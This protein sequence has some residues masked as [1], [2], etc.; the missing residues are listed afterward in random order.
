MTVIDVTDGTVIVVTIA[1][2]VV[3]DTTDVTADPAAEAPM[4]ADGTMIADVM[5][6]ATT[7][8]VTM[9]VEEVEAEVMIAAVAATTEVLVNFWHEK[10]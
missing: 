8:D 6:T 2:T 3:V 9:S 4:S 1:T 10:I 5:T 7:A